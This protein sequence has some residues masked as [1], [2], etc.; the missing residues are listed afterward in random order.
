MANEPSRIQFCVYEQLRVQPWTVN[1]NNHAIHGNFNV[2][3]RHGCHSLAG[4]VYVSNL[5]L[6]HDVGQLTRCFVYELR[7]LMH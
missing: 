6:W 3:V 4:F 7:L 5:C 1:L 2:E